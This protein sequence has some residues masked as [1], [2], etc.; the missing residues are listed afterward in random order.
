MA[1]PIVP[2]ESIPSHGLS[3]EVRDWAKV[4]CG[5]ALEGSTRFVDGQLEIVRV[6]PDVRATGELRG[7][8][9]VAC[10][11]CGEPLDFDVATTVSCRY[12]A[13]RGIDEQEP[14]AS[15]S[16]DFGEY[17]G[18]ALDLTHVVRESFSLERPVRF[19]C[20]DF[21]P[22]DQ[23]DKVDAACLARFHARAQLPPPEP[24]PRLA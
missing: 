20:A 24:D 14:E 19:L 13:P 12:L 5:E 18:V 17:D 4:A 6:G 2:I 1:F 8:V 16:E 23:A 10:D 21:A 9:R 7:G 22:P 15:D 11:R 3:V